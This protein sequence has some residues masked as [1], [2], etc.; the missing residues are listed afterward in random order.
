MNDNNHDRNSHRSTSSKRK[1]KTLRGNGNRNLQQNG[2][3]RKQIQAHPEE[4]KVDPREENVGESEGGLK[5]NQAKPLSQ[6][7]KLHRPQDF[8]FSGT[9]PCA[10]KSNLLLSKSAIEGIT[11][12]FS[13]LKIGVDKQR[14]SIGG[15]NGFKPHH[16]GAGRL[17]RAYGSALIRDQTKGLKTLDIG[18][19]L[20][21]EIS[22]YIAHPHDPTNMVSVFSNMHATVP[23]D[24]AAE[25]YRWQNQRRRVN[26][27]I[28]EHN[29]REDAIADYYKRDPVYLNL[30]DHMCHHKIN[31]VLTVVDTKTCAKCV[32]SYEAYTSVESFYYPGVSEGI[33]ARLE[34]DLLDEQVTIKP[35][36]YV[37]LNNYFA[38]IQRKL[39]NDPAVKEQ[40][41]TIISG[42]VNKTEFKIVLNGYDM[43]P[44]SNGL[45]APE[46]THTITCKPD[47]KLWVE[48]DVQGNPFKYQHHIPHLLDDEYFYVSTSNVV[49]VWERTHRFPNKDITGDTFK[50]TPII[51]GKWTKEQL[52]HRSQVTSMPAT[53]ADLMVEVTDN[54]KDI[55]ATTTISTPKDEIKLD[56][57]CADALPN[58]LNTQYYELKKKQANEKR[59][60]F[61]THESKMTSHREF[62]EWLAMQFGNSKHHTFSLKKV[63]GEVYI[64]VRSFMKKWF[65]LTQVDQG[66]SAMAK[67]EDVVAAYVAI[68][69]KQNALSVRNTM[70][71]AQKQNKNNDAS[72]FSN[73]DAYCIARLIRLAEEERWARIVE[74]Q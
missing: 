70:A 16:H 35:Q 71:N 46:S 4:R 5:R 65:F 45:T 43:V 68:G 55:M 39:K 56:N 9:T 67:L 37:Y 27:L 44:D 42:D 62:V 2:Y 72:V 36:A 63:D 17:G 28:M 14:L 25:L 50:V 12:A 6:A 15:D 74:K 66:A 21:R 59:I 33:Q 51:A 23:L 29:S 58:I 73:Q 60:D 47:G 31:E 13:Y 22:S 48:V 19:S 24:D 10:F 41:R 8:I 11:E 1:G 20:V 38:A 32:A 30:E 57:K 26:D 49:Y 3:V 54:W 18:T 40:L 53:F 61:A 7:P 52:K 34:R 64:V 69:I